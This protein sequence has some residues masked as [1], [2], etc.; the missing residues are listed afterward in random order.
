MSQ[1]A[2][3]A[4]CGRKSTG[5][6]I[7]H[8]DHALWA[9]AA[10]S[11]ENRRGRSSSAGWTRLQPPDLL[12]TS[13]RTHRYAFGKKG[14]FENIARKQNTQTQEHLHELVDFCFTLRFA[15]LSANGLF[16][17]LNQPKG[18]QSI[19][20]YTQGMP[21]ENKAQRDK[22]RKQQILGWRILVQMS[23]DVN[24]VNV[25]NQAYW[26]SPQARPRIV[27]WTFKN[28]SL[29]KGA[30]PSFVQ[31]WMLPSFWSKHS[32]LWLAI[33]ILARQKTQRRHMSCWWKTSGL[34][35]RIRKPFVKGSLV[36]KLPMYWLFVRTWIQ[37][38]PALYLVCN[39]T[40]AG[41]GPTVLPQSASIPVL[42]TWEGRVSLQ[43][44]L[45]AQ[46]GG[47][48][49]WSLDSRW[50]SLFEAQP[51]A[52]EA[53][54]GCV[55]ALISKWRFPI[56]NCSIEDARIQRVASGQ[57][58]TRSCRCIWH[59]RSQSCIGVDRDGQS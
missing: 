47:G 14:M 43:I 37:A 50:G 40:R 21:K 25:A 58:L 1:N 57:F 19:F 54:A 20:L 42:Y 26:P 5:S 31:F 59:I 56:H 36:E 33:R 13:T 10:N 9:P 28:M 3:K 18:H 44:P 55:A 32:K 41:S 16:P 6:S 35:I 27:T 46:R 51:T 7:G 11:Y 52:A 38:Y 8:P 34:I 4:C 29:A 45:V 48:T 2:T 23:E 39:E 49:V 17:L 24:V 30:F 22:Q 12:Q 15:E 53:D